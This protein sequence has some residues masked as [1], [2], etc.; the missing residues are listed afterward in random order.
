MYNIY[1]YVFWL[2]NA[3]EHKLCAKP[4]ET[5]KFLALHWIMWLKSEWCQRIFNELVHFPL[6][7]HNFHHISDK[8]PTWRKYFIIQPDISKATVLK[9]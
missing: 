4:S 7:P 8:L 6:S 1:V 5:D 9:C 2:T 3:E